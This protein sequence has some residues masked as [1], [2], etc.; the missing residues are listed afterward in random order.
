MGWVRFLKFVGFDIE[1]VD[2]VND[3]MEIVRV[4]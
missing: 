2:I 1:D 3:R 4:K